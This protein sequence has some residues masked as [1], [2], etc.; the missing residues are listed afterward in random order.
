M[1]DLMVEHNHWTLVEPDIALAAK[2]VE[3]QVHG[4]SLSTRGSVWACSLCEDW[5][6]IGERADDIKAHL[7][8]E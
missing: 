6:G 3:A 1:F 7:L 2:A 8:D 4:I 5:D